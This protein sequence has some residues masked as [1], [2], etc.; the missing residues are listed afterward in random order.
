[1]TSQVGREFQA[2][3]QRRWLGGPGVVV[4]ELLQIRAAHVRALEA[5][6]WR[7]RGETGRRERTR[8]TEQTFGSVDNEL[9]VRGARDEHRELSIERRRS[10]VHNEL[11]LGATG[12]LQL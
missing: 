1:V 6:T 4:D 5:D 12:E 10:L 2:H 8:R 11:A 9:G 7:K 3:R